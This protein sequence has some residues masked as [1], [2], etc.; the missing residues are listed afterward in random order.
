[1][2]IPSN[3]RSRYLLIQILLMVGLIL[4]P[5]I[6]ASSNSSQLNYIETRIDTQSNGIEINQE[7]NHPIFKVAVKN[8]AFNLNDPVDEVSSGREIRSMIYDTLISYNSRTGEYE[9]RLAKDWYMTENGRQWTFILQQDIEFHD[10]TVFNA[11]IV[12]FNLERFQ[13]PSNHG[14][15]NPFPELTWAIDIQSLVER[16]DIEGEFE[17]TIQLT[18]DYSPFLG[19]LTSVL[20]IS[21]TNYENENFVHSYGTG[22]YVYDPERETENITILVRNNDYFQGNPP[23]EEIHFLHVNNYETEFDYYSD[24]NNHVIDFAPHLKYDFST[25]EAITDDGSWTWNFSEESGGI[26]FGY[27]N[28]A[29][30]ILS[31]SLVRI[32]LNHAVDSQSY[33][34]LSPPGMVTEM[35]NWFSSNLKFYDETVSGYTYNLNLAADLLDEAGYF[36]DEEGFR[37]H[38]DFY[39]FNEIERFETLNRSLSE[40]GITTSYD[41]GFNLSKFIDRDY[42]V[43]IIGLGGEEG[44]DPAWL[45]NT[46]REDGRYNW[47]GYFNPLIDQYLDLGETTVVKQEREFYYSQIQKILRQDTPVINLYEKKGGYLI[48]TEL[49][50]YYNP[51]YGFNFTISPNGNNLISLNQYETKTNSMNNVKVT[52]DPIYLWRSDMV[53]ENLGSVA[54]KVNSDLSFSRDEQNDLSKQFSIVVDNPHIEYSLKLYYDRKLEADYQK[55]EVF[56]WSQDSGTWNKLTI[57]EQDGDLQYIKIKNQGSLQIK[58]I[59]EINNSKDNLDLKF[60]NFYILIIFISLMAIGYLY[61][62]KNKS[63]LNEPS[64]SIN[65]Y[66]LFIPRSKDTMKI[67]GFLVAIIIIITASMELYWNDGG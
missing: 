35:K 17:I 33:M 24:I 66:R 12:K 30:S 49:Y 2:P 3:T 62:K 13:D 9:P 48:S 61:F 14:Y 41:I 32:A 26:Y 43:G 59:N 47:G 64:K 16:V 44:E 46:L 7:L 19:V 57:L 8:F 52:S 39:I 42:D 22:P 25:K 1:M 53:I 11:S 20:F 54:I 36:A 28:F 29:N 6:D 21:P 58:I 51:S 38:L 23:F 34:A 27:L 55:S 15:P 37:F 56:G 65:L 63:F 50:D 67:I 10:G 5:F 45:R 40:L 4:T 31:D 60:L 18:K